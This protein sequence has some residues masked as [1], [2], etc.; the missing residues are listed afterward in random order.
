M[1]H[2]FDDGD[3]TEITEYITDMA[4]EQAYLMLVEHGSAS[5]DP[6]FPHIKLI[7]GLIKHFASKEAY[8]QCAILLDLQA[9]VAIDKLI[10]PRVKKTS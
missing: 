10:R 9:E 3:Y 7:E 5:F 1:N 6:D 2:K 8:E 4:A